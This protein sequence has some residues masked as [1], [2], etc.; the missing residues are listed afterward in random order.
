MCESTLL[1]GNAVLPQLPIS[2]ELGPLY[3]ALLE[4][5]V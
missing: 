1:P 3:R 2:A 4:K 5:E